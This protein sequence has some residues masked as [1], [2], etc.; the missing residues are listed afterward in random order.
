MFAQKQ[1]SE[2][3]CNL[4]KCRDA[5]LKNN[6]EAQFVPYEATKQ[7]GNGTA[8]ILAPHPD[9]E[10]IGCGG[11]IIKHVENNDDV[12]VII[13]T[14]GS[15]GAPEFN[16]GAGRV[17]DQDTRVKN[18]IK[19]RE[20]ESKKAGSALG[21][22]EPS[23][24]EIKD[25]T[26]EY[27]EKYIQMVKDLIEKLKPSSVYSPSIYEMH[28]DH[29]AL[30]IVVIE[31]I[32]RSQ[33]NPDLFMY[34]IGRPIPSPNM[35]LDITQIWEQKLKAIKCF[36]S[37]LNVQ[38]F[39]ETT[40]SLNRY[41]TFT[42]PASVKSAEAYFVISANDIQNTVLDILLPESEHH[43]SMDLY[44]DFD[45]YLKIRKGRRA[46]YSKWENLVCENMLSELFEYASKYEELKIIKKEKEDYKNRF[47]ELDLKNQEY[48]EI[49]QKY[50]VDQDERNKI[51]FEQQKTISEMS[52][53]Q[54]RIYSSK[55]FILY[56][57]VT[58]FLGI[59][60]RRFT[61]K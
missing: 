10:V 8:L 54:D 50:K 11:A 44:S 41:R 39:D 38:A 2:M 47:L 14:D 61:Y 57:W 13:L 15:L 26:L 51:I 16:V 53:I 18:Y 30:A 48:E 33:N 45:E 28:P 40:L 31:A 1:L 37:Q 49:F 36:N 19:A 27:N 7:V 21:Y 46:V 25:R 42:L 55:A 35:L 34:E 4:L 3:S 60:K 9:D 6:F 52:V 17:D 22:G 29:K 59:V 20:E 23:F 43:K 32:R 24:W 56:K 58:A 5:I 12:H